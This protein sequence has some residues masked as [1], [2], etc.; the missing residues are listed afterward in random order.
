MSDLLEKRQMGATAFI[1]RQ[2]SKRKFSPPEA[3]VLVIKD[4]GKIEMSSGLP[5][6]RT[7]QPHH[8]T[9][10]IPTGGRQETH[11]GEKETL[12]QTVQREMAEELSGYSLAVIEALTQQLTLKEVQ[13]LA[14]PFL[15]A[16]WRTHRQTID[17]IPA[18]TAIQEFD[19]LPK[20]VQHEIDRGVGS[21]GQERFWAPI[22]ALNGWYEVLARSDAKDQRINFLFRPQALTAAH[23]YYLEY[24]AHLP[25]EIVTS[26]IIKGNEGVY[27]SVQKFM[28]THGGWQLNNG[29][30]LADGSLNFKLLSEEDVN[31][32]VGRHH[33]S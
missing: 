30:M 21:V 27:G 33:N 14:L 9:Y 7:P 11:S 13:R 3:A 31:Y 19:A 25:S 22:R 23:L 32:L 24:V 18:V 10:G 16:Q 4:E 1:V 29:T 26:Q 8:L 17:F 28:D 6:R 2:H 5:Q 20:E 15:V 12:T